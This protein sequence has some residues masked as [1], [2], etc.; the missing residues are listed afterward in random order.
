M[1]L[2]LS[3]VQMFPYMHEMQNSCILQKK[4]YVLH[5]A[6]NFIPSGLTLVSTTPTT[7]TLNWTVP[8]PSPD[9]DG[10]VIYLMRSSGSV[11]ALKIVGGSVN[12]HILEGL[13]PCTSYTISIRAYQDILGPESQPLLVRTNACEGKYFSNMSR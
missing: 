4:N 13:T 11:K 12:E 5:T 3:E 2:C 1:H 9:A 8:S 10:Y 7:L 6:P